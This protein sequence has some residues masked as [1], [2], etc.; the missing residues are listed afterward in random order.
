LRTSDTFESGVGNPAADR[1]DE[2]RAEQVARGLT[3]DQSY[4]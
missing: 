1:S 2:T 3:S 4:A